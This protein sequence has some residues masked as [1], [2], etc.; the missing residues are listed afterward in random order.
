VRIL[1]A[2]QGEKSLI[3]SLGHLGTDLDP[4]ILACAARYPHDPL[5]WLGDDACVT[6][7]P[8]VVEP[9]AEVRDVRRP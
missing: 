9:P 1:C 5:C 2:S 7:Q 4:F 6:G 8:V 3:Y